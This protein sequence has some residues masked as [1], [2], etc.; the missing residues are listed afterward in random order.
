MINSV[1]GELLNA[2]RT[3]GGLQAL[4]YKNWSASYSQVSDLAIAVANSIACRISSPQAIGIVVERAP[5]AYIGIL[6]IIFSGCSYIPLSPKSNNKRLA[7]IFDDS[8][9]NYI[10]G[11]K[12]AID[13]L[14]LKLDSGQ[15]GHIKFIHLPEYDGEI[16]NLPKKRGG[17]PILLNSA[18][19]V[20]KTDDLVYTLY[21][22]GSTG[23]PKS[24]QVKNSNLLSFLRN[25]KFLYPLSPGFRASQT[26]DLSFDPSVSDIFFTL[27]SGGTLCILPDDE[28]MMPHL[29][30]SREQISFWNSVPTIASFL[31]KMGLLNTNA[32][33][34]LRHSMFCGEQ[35]PKQLADAWR[36]SAP[37]STI[38][39]LYGPTEATIYISRYVYGADSVE[40]EFKN[41][42]IPIGKPYPFHEFRLIDD[43]NLPVSKGVGEI[44]FKGPQVT[45]GYFNDPEKTKSSF[46]SFHW[47]ESGEKWYRSGDIGFYNSNGDLECLGRRD[48]QIKIA[49]RRIELGEIEA[50]LRASDL[51]SNVAVVPTRDNEGI[52]N[53]CAAYITDRLSNEEIKILKKNCL[54]YLDSIF[55][56][57][58]IYFLD[59]LPLTISG[60]ID[61]KKLELIIKDSN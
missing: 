19:L 46:V 35:F 6:G 52:I 60:K 29:Y 26:F 48:S 34:S 54:K 49:G 59:I 55:V 58:H 1:A 7:S 17:E 53:G 24:V 41:S 30:I 47:D 36:I 56:P 38:E 42:I 40:M 32:F 33:P 21:T 15:L 13:D 57:K 27:M 50:A 51:I 9:I 45:S 11:S 2:F 20:G 3:F 10:L 37:N 31:H 39:N 23:Q 61:K 4:S 44:V 14:L 5:S 16:N 18:F 28:L 22:S 25:M 8:K 43:E 12:K